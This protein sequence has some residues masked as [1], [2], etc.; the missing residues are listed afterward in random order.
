MMTSFMQIVLPETED[1]IESKKAAF[2]EDLKDPIF[3]SAVEYIQKQW[4]TREK[5]RPIDRLAN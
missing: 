1:E 2:L 4:F 5:A 3:Q